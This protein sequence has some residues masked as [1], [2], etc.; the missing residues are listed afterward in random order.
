[1]E[2]VAAEVA[3]RLASAVAGP[4]AVEG[5]TVTVGVSIGVA[6]YP[7]SGST[8]DDLVRVADAAMFSTKRIRKGSQRGHAVDGATARG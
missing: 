6:L 7:V 2:A 1:M 5:R 8:P 3:E 4:I